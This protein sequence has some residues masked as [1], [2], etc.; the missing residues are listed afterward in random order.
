LL[1]IQVHPVSSRRVA[2]R[3]SPNS[4]KKRDTNYYLFP[5]IA[6]RLQ[7]A[8]VRVPLKSTFSSRAKHKQ[9][10]FV[11][12]GCIVQAALRGPD[13]MLLMDTDVRA[14]EGWRKSRTVTQLHVPKMQLVTLGSKSF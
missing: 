7:Q 2:F 11:R 10:T 14:V 6:F 9:H 13:K 1:N 8:C 4:R 3:V 12:M 5:I